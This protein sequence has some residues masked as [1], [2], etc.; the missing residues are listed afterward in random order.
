M[1]DTAVAF[2][3]DVTPPVQ[4]GGEPHRWT[5]REYHRL[6]DAGGFQFGDHG[7]FETRVEL[8]HGVIYNKF[9]PGGG[10]PGPLRWTRAMYE[11]LVENGGLNGLRVELI[12]GEVVDKMSPHSTSHSTAVAL[13]QQVL[14]EVFSDGAHVR[15]QLPIRAMN[16]SEPEPDIAVVP[17]SAR[18]YAHEHPA[19]VLLVV[20][21][22]NTTLATDRTKK[23]AVYAESGFPEYWIVNVRDAC[24]EVH[25]DP[26]GDT[27]LT[28]TVVRDDESVS[29]LTR[30]TASIAVADLLP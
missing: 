22:S 27:Y 21:V 28:R 4:T 7:P 23:M 6:G 19:S 1:S 24:L 17:G 9:P 8:L 10:E 3:L 26:Q 25:R 18:D 29:P 14:S 20:E 2:D 11:R 30:S 12:H 5:V 13:V 16:E 15:A